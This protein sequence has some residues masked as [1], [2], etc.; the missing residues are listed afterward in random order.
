MANTC[1]AIVRLAV[2]VPPE[3]VAVTVYT[4]DG[5]SAVGVPDNSPV[6]VSKLRPVGSAG[7]ILHEIVAPPLLEGVIGSIASSTIKSNTVVE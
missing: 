2:S 7:E 5:D 3:F 1:T 4:C 6:T